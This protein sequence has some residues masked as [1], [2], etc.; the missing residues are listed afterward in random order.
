[1]SA[2]TDVVLVLLV[3]TNLA[4][5][6]TSRL[7][8]C[9]RFE[10]FQGI[11]LGALTMLVPA[12]RP[13]LPDLLLTGA[14]TVV[15]GGIFPWLLFRALRETSARREGEPLVGYGLSLLLGALL[16]G[17]SLWLGSRLPLP[18]PHAGTLVVPAAF[19]SILTGLFLL[20]SRASALTQV[21]GYLVLENGIYVFGVALTH[22]EPLLVALG[23]LLDVFVAVFVMGITIFHIGREFDHIDVDRLSTLR[24]P[25]P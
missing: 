15:K 4:L 25:P 8:A 6:G 21:L 9:I 5:L 3:L 12:G 20:V 13:T 22:E 10:A 19:F 24:D 14:S 11:L 2:S 1:M 16:L 7:A 18:A 23:V 17:I